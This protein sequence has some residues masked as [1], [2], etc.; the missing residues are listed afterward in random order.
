MKTFLLPFSGVLAVL[1][2][3]TT[4]ILS[5]SC[6]HRRPQITSSIKEKKVRGLVDT[7]GFA[8]TARQM[9]SLMVRIKRMEGDSLTKWSQKNLTCRVAVCPHDDYTYVGYLYPALLQHVKAPTVILFGV[10][11]KA[12]L[13]GLR[14]RI[15]LG[16]FTA[17]QGPWGTIPV[18]PLREELIARLDTSLYTVNDSMMAMEHSLEALLPFLQ[19]FDRRLTILPILVPYLS[20]EK[21]D[22]IA[23]ALANALQDITSEHHLQWGPDFAIVISTDAVHYGD[24]G[25]HGNNYAPYGT[26]EKGTSLA[27]A[28]EHTIIDST[29][30]GRVTPD[31]LRRFFHYTVSEQDYTRYKWTWCGRYSVPQGLLTAWYL[32]RLEKAP[33]L[34]GILI[35]Y[36]NSIDHPRIPVEDLGMG[37]TAPASP[38]HWVGYAAI[39]YE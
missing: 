11:H 30:T 3:M 1:A 19:Y 28:H 7:V 38:H 26:D 32:A 17:Y 27:V 10:A 18:S 36:R 21:M 4:F 12:R 15:V 25:W 24:S 37:T 35:G 22:T 20:F 13:L 29:L 6:V 39:G 16:S 9:D 2:I 14:D 5:S 8:H 31:R 33:P 23:Q 34:S